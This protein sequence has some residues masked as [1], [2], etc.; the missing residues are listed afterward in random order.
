MGRCILALYRSAA[1]PV[2]QQLGNRL[3]ERK[4]AGELPRGLALLPSEDPY[5]GTPAMGQFVAT[6]LGAEIAPLA[7]LGHWWMLEDPATA[8]DRLVA[9]W[10]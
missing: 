1:Q 6:H 7:G 9:F 5:V 8:A 3:A 10:A 4:S 2:M